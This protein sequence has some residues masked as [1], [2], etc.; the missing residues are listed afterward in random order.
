ME[1]T[2]QGLLDFARPPRLHR[3]RHDLRDTLRRAVNLMEG[4][5]KQERVTI[6]AD[7]PVCPVVVEGD[8]EQLHQVF[9]NLLLNG[10]EAMTQGGTLGVAIQL[11]QDRKG[12]CRVMFRDSGSGIPEPVLQRIFEPFMTTKERGTGL[13][14]A[15]SRRIV[16][17]HGG[18]LTAANHPGGGA[19]FAV[20][21]PSAAEGQAVCPGNST[22]PPGA[23]TGRQGSS[24]KHNQEATNA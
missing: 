10:I 20:E 23:A 18:R 9:I 5:A 3:L 24:P 13:G 2:I 22:A 12:E 1:K 15:V 8:P 14:L 11:G 4:R 6:S 19:V 7:L 16:E 21:L 17:E